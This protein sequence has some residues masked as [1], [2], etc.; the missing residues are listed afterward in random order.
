MLELKIYAEKCTDVNKYCTW[1][2][3]KS[4]LALVY[5]AAPLAYTA[6]TRNGFTS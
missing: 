1:Q 3:I 6:R 4:I 2:L 5:R